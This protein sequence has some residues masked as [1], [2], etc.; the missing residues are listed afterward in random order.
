[1]VKVGIFR[2]FFCH[3]K[4]NCDQQ[5]VNTGEYLEYLEYTWGKSDITPS[6][7][8]H[9]HVPLIQC[10][11]CVCGERGG[12]WLIYKRTRGKASNNHLQLS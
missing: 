2:H 9:C 7:W 5:V 1:M 12:V 6:H 10:E 4:A 8:I 11:A 3:I